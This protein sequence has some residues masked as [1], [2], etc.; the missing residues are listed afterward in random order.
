MVMKRGLEAP[1]T[2]KHAWNRYAEAG[3]V[4]VSGL[5]LRTLEMGCGS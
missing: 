1:G 3:S 5:V 4:R 2:G